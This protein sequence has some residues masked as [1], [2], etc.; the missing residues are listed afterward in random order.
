MMQL[1]QNDPQSDFSNDFN[2]VSTSMGKPNH[3]PQTTYLKDYQTPDYGIQSVDLVFE[4]K[5]KDTLVR[6][7]CQV[8]KNQSKGAHSRPLCLHGEALEL[9]SLEVD[10]QSLE[11]SQYEVTDKFLKVNNLPESC[12]LSIQTRIQPQENTQLSGLYRSNQMFCTQCE[13]EGFRR[14]TYFLDR[15]DNL[16]VFT[17]TILADPHQYPVLLSN[18]DLVDK[19][20]LEDGRHFAK[21]KD[22]FPKPSYLF[23]LVAGDLECVSDQFTTQSGKVVELKI[24]VEK[25]NIHK[26]DHAMMALKNAM[27]WDEKAFGREYDLGIYMI[28]AVDDFNMGAMENKGLNIFNSKY[29]LANAA[30]ATDTDFQNIEAVIGHEYFHNWSGNRVTCRDW[31]QLSLKEGL[32]VFREQQFSADRGSKTVKRIQDVRLVRSRQFSED[33]GPMA[34]PVRPESYMEI[35]NFYTMTVYYKGAEVIRML[36]TLL[37]EKGFRKGMD[38][39]FER[40]DGQAV[41]CDHFVSALADANEVDL[42]QFQ[43]WYFQAGTPV[44]RAQGHYVPEKKEYHLTLNQHCPPTP[45]QATKAPFLMPIRV[46]LMTSSGQ[47]MNAP[48]QAGSLCCEKADRLTLLFKE[49]Q[50]N[51]VFEQVP[52]APVISFL[53][54]FSCPCKLEFDYTI[55]QLGVI[56]RHAPDMFSRWEASHSLLTQFI[57]SQVNK[58]PL[59]GSLAL[60]NECFQALFDHPLEDQALWAEMLVLP[61]FSALGEHLEQIPVHPLLDAMDALKE[62][63]ARTLYSS[64]KT[65]YLALHQQETQGMEGQDIGRRA[66]KNVLLGYMVIANEKEALPLCQTQFKESQNMTDKMGALQALSWTQGSV[67]DQL[68]EAFYQE[69]KHE[70]LVVNK[71]L[72]LQAQAQKGDVLSKVMALLDHEAFDMS[73]PN[74]VYALVGG[75]SQNAR[76]FH[77]K[78]G[79]GYKFLAQMVMLLNAKNPQVAARMI[80]P[81]LHWKKFE[82][83]NRVSMRDALNTIKNQPKL[84]EDVFEL[85]SKALSDA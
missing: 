58:T 16:A 22:P 13:A 40:H 74:K 18:G 15:P 41:T 56:M 53:G 61:T 44:V 49:T 76:H 60:F 84:S 80:E 38:V 28:V 47:A 54:D 1:Y 24:Y 51:F 67:V 65:V 69:W 21:W 19:G 45:G 35:N 30:M 8:F 33:S 39:Y 78:D 64:M 5:E 63:L 31:F 55:E 83:D 79:K 77:A 73:N 75:F 34:H 59:N 62:S 12:T 48:L 27:A 81:L 25:Q 11:A 42:S 57:L 66:L 36:H 37:G 20:Q 68:I 52:Q 70:P 7:T 43:R 9:V 17:T 71:W 2:Q 23:A 46:D 26:C 85:V 72:S 6:T 4:L 14:I 10:G 82:G 29:V 50:Q 32:T 3:T